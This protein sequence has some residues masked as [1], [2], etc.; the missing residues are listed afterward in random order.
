MTSP[1]ATQAILRMSRH[2]RGACLLEA[3]WLSARGFSA[4]RT[5]FPRSLGTLVERNLNRV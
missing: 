2:E 5:H 1:A 4:V 3:D